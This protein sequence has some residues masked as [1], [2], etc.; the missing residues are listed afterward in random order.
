M[1]D[2]RKRERTSAKGRFTRKVK[3]VNN[4][5]T[6]QLSKETVEIRFQELLQAWVE[7]QEKHENYVAVAADTDAEETYLDT[8]MIELMND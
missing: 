5:V 7:L 3:S 4:S 2:E 1:A 8:P 6:N